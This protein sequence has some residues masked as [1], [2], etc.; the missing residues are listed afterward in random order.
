VVGDLNI[1][2]LR[3]VGVDNIQISGGGTATGVP[4]VVPPNVVALTEATK[5]LTAS[6]ERLTGA[7]QTKTTPEQL[8]SV[9]TVEVIGYEEQTRPQ[10]SESEEQQKRRRP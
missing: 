6:T 4:R 3:V 5:V 2:A 8:P 10:S 7:A 1:A 9:I